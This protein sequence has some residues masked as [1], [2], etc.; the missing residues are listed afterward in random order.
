MTIGNSTPNIEKKTYFSA[1]TLIAGSIKVRL[2]QHLT[3]EYVE[4]AQA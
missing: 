3:A 1:T 4:K 2:A